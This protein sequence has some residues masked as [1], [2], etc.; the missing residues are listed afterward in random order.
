MFRKSN[1]L[2]NNNRGIH[3]FHKRL[4]DKDDDKVYYTDGACYNNGYA[5][6]VSGCGVF[7]GPGMNLSFRN[8]ENEDWDQCCTNNF[9]ELYAIKG[10]LQWHYDNES[11]DIDAV[12]VTDSRYS[13]NCVEEWSPK[14]IQNGWF[15]CAGN[16]IVHQEVIQEI[17]GYKEDFKVHF[18]WVPGHSGDFGNEEAR[19]LAQ[20][21]CNDD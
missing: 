5:N 17:L 20:A 2:Y 9:A 14:W 8:P 1:T 16:R 6:A 21:A 10:A 13:I 19:D 7:G 11:H 15:N 4:Y 3:Q 18:F 12:I